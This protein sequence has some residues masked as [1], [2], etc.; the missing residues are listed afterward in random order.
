MS[1]TLN[2]QRKKAKAPPLTELPILNTGLPTKTAEKRPSDLFERTVEQSY[3]YTTLL[4]LSEP[5]TLHHIMYDL[6]EARRLN[7]GITKVGQKRIDS[8]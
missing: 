4:S 6:A 2:Q 7:T 3:F 8:G 5:Q 1:E